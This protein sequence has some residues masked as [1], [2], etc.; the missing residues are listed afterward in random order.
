MPR[1]NESPLSRALIG[2][3][4]DSS[5]AGQLLV[6]GELLCHRTPGP[7][8]SELAPSPVRHDAGGAFL[9]TTRQR[10]CVGTRFPGQWRAGSKPPPARAIQYPGVE[11][12]ADDAARHAYRLPRWRRQPGIRGEATTRRA[13]PA[14]HC[15][16]SAA[17]R[18]GARQ[19]WFT[20]QSPRQAYPVGIRLHV[21]CTRDTR[22]TIK[23]AQQVFDLRKH[24]WSLCASTRTLMFGT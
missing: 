23:I 16:V 6:G 13:S 3:A 20:P 5:C 22:P 2:M 10:R 15:D 19:H 12:C 18:H 24:G 17:T 4:G 9:S 11:F 1:S 21:R 14:Y 8:D 7:L